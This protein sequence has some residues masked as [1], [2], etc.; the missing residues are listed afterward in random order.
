MSEKTKRH[1]A[2]FDASEILIVPG[3]FDGY[4]VRLVEGAGFK[5]AAISG[6]GVS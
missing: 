6:T 4:S 2:L 5:S 3:V 1:K